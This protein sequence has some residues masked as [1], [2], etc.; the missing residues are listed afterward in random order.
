MSHVPIPLPADPAG[1]TDER[2]M[3]LD[4]LEY[5]RAVLLRKGDGLDVTQLSTPLAPSTLTI[6]GLIRHMT[7]VEDCW[8]PER[9]E[10]GSGN[11][12]WISA[13]WNVDA[14]WEMTSA[15]GMTFDELRRDFD[16]A[17][18]RSRQVTATFASLD[19]IGRGMPAG[20][21][22]SLRWVLIHM[23]EE[24]ARHC[25]HADFIAQAIDNRTGD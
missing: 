25:G 21:P 14:D 6:G 16:L 20:R 2:T 3:L 7:L 5:Y 19:D 4:F 15:A 24:Y 12:P 18:E 17:C 1:T 9:M 10:G 23:V 8:F 22:L 13:P 11:E